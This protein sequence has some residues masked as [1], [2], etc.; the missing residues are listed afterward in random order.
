MSARPRR[1]A[2]QAGFTLVETLIASALLGVVLTMCY[3]F[4]ASMQMEV[5]RVDSR[6]QSNDQ[7]TLAAHEL[8]REVRSGNVLY[9]PT[10]E[11]SNAGTSPDGSAIPPGFS[12]RIYTQ[13]N[14]IQRCVQ[15]RVV[16]TG[17]LQ[18]RSWADQWE[19]DPSTLV[20]GWRT[21][22]TGIVNPTSQPPFSLDSSA[23][24]ATKSVSRLVDVDFVANANSTLGA[25]AEVQLSVAGRNTEY[26]PTNSGLCSDIPTP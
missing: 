16:D 25:S 17:V 26:F 1:R 20:S 2:D 4:L 3:A 8:D 14:G 22:A 15:W 23:G 21:V 5:G 13:A 24:D 10:Q 7:A 11:G 12:V 19:N 6:Q 9:D 18:K